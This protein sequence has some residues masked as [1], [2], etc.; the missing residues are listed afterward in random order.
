MVK[1][2]ADVLIKN[3]K[4]IM[5]MDDQL[6]VLENCSLAI[7]DGIIVDLGK[8]L[9]NKYLAEEVFDASNSIITPGLIDCHTHLIYSKSRENEYE[10]RLNGLSYLEILQKGGG[11]LSSASHMKSANKDDLINKALFWL[12]EFEKQGVLTVEIKSGY[13]L[14]YEAELKMLEVINLLKKRT[15]QIIIGT[16]LAHVIPK[17]FKEKEQEYIDLVVNKMLPDFRN[18]SENFDIFVEN[19]AF[20]FS[21]AD[22]LIGKAKELKYNIKIHSNQINRL[23][24]VNLAKKYDALS[25]D[26]MDNVTEDELDILSETNTTAVLLPGASYF[27]NSNKIPPVNLFKKKN[28]DIAIST[29]FNPGSCPSPNLHMMM[30]LAIHRFGMKP[31]DVWKS[32]TIN[33]AKALG[34]DNSIGSIKIGKKSSILSWN[35]P[36]YMYPI[37]HFGVNFVNKIFY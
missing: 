6:G 36:N 29:D 11:I 34:V 3:A 30:S 4:R 35:M 8:D 26:H 5:T 21:Q 7:R 10:D 2:T 18:L 27:I 16:F 31:N 17:D 1:N 13:G 19:G 20:S 23:G 15:K 24:A 22:Y 33:A 37:Y 9:N 12:N 14:S 25:V 28:I 32:V